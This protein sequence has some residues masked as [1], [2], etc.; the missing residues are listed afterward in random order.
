L[1]P[2][3]HHVGQYGGLRQNSPKNR[4]PRPPKRGLGFLFAVKSVCKEQIAAK[5]LWHMDLA[6]SPMNR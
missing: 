5:D 6:L 4:K 1:L 3:Y 2:P